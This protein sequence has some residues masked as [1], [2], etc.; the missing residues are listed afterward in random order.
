MVQNIG[1]GG[2]TTLTLLNK[3]QST[4]LPLMPAT[5]GQPAIYAVMIGANDIK[6]GG[7]LA[8]IQIQMQQLWYAVQSAGAFLVVLTVPDDAVINAT[9]NG[10]TIR[11]SLNSWI[12]SHPWPNLV[13]DVASL[14]AFSDFTNTTYYQWTG[15][16]NNGIHFTQTAQ[17]IIA[18]AV[19]NALIS[20]GYAPQPVP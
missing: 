10:E 15:A 8:S 16:G 9:N 1:H 11:N 13:V 17:Q 20:Q 12:K 18:N 14:P 7:N 19:Y 3:L 4:I 5:T 2:S 6:G